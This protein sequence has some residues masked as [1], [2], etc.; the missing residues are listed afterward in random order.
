MILECAL[1]SIVQ[2]G[3]LLDSPGYAMAF[4]LHQLYMRTELINTVHEPHLQELYDPNQLQVQLD[5]QA[6]SFIN[7]QASQCLPSSSNF[8]LFACM[9]LSL[10]VT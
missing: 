3:A 4:T 6:D 10:A 8:C 5:E 7:R 2:A 1:P 9:L